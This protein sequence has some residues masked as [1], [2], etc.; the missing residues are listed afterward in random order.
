MSS[1][2]GTGSTL[3]QT[4]ITK[5]QILQ[6]DY[7]MMAFV[8]V[9]MFLRL[10]CQII[11]RKRLQL[12]D[13][14]LYIAYTFYLSLCVLYIIVTPILFEIQDITTGVLPM[15]SDFLKTAGLTSR[16]IWSAQTCFYS[17][18]WSVKFSLL[19]LY[20]KLSVG[21]QPIYFRIWQAI[22]V[23]CFLVRYH[24]SALLCKLISCR[25]SLVL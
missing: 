9:F 12:Q 16:L 22:V 5:E 10:A 13:Y 3:G 25:G 24:C 1:G 17:C 4:S 14:F 23:V 15:P 6:V 2:G 11:R 8:T 7:A 21:L 19:S 20:R 18:L